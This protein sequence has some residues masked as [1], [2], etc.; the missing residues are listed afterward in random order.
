MALDEQR[1]QQLIEQLAC[2]A[3]QMRMAA[4]AILFLEMHKPL[5]FL[6]AQMLWAAQPLLSLW[7][8]QA[9]VRDIALLLEDRVSVEQLIERLESFKADESPLSQLHRRT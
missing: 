9:D 6:G 2:R 8:N 5:A 7:L 4:P 3:A 1:R